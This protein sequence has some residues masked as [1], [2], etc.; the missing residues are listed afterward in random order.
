LAE[1]GC[2]PVPPPPPLI[3]DV[4]PLPNRTSSF[5]PSFTPPLLSTLGNEYSLGAAAAEVLVESFKPLLA[6]LGNEYSLGAAAA[7]VLVESFKPLL[8]T[9]DN[10]YSLGTAAPEVL[11][12]DSAGLE[13]VV[14][15]HCPVLSDDVVSKE[16]SGSSS[17]SI[18]ST[19]ARGGAEGGAG[20]GPNGG[21]DEGGFGAV[22]GATLAGE[23]DDIPLWLLLLFPRSSKEDELESLGFETN[24]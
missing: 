16:D 19:V 9:L 8:A 10:E 4:K 23:S 3:E 18:S 2:N 20:G 1:L 11:V 12:E 6:T 5:L 15:F 22:R 21:P 24:G 7:E 13:R 14:L 17:W